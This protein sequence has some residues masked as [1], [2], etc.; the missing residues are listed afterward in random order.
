[1]RPPRVLSDRYLRRRK[2][3]DKAIDLIDEASIA[4]R[5][6]GEAMSPGLRGLT[7]RDCGRP[8][9]AWTPLP[10]GRTTG[11]RAGQAAGAD[12]GRVRGDE[13]KLAAGAWRHQRL[14]ERDI[15]AL[16]STQM[17]GVPVDRMLEGEAEKLLHME[18]FYISRSSDRTPP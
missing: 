14:T 5:H 15:A 18:E 3:P 1:M 13:V 7:A 4:A 11:S 10:S 9:R 2:L 6:R 12:P 8:R 16:I 17:T